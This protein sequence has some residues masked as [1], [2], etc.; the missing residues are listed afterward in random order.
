MVSRSDVVQLRALRADPRRAVLKL[1]IEDMHNAL[2]PIGTY[3]PEQEAWIEAL[4]TSQYVL[5]VKPRQLGF[6]TITLAFLFLKAL[7]SRFGRKCLSMVHEESALERLQVMTRVFHDNLPVEIQ[8]G[9][10]KNNLTVTQLAKVARDGRSIPGSMLV[11]QLA[12]GRGQ[13]RSWTYNDYHATEMSKWPSGTSAK[14]S[15]EGRSADEEAFGSAISTIHDP[16]ASVIVEST[17]DG[18]RGLFFDLYQQAVT[19][20]KWAFVF[21]K[22][23]DVARY[24]ERLT[25]PQARALEADLDS[26]ERNLV[27]KFGLTLGQIAWRRTKMK[28]LRMTGITFRREFPLTDMEPFLLDESGWFNQEALV[29]LLQHVPSLG[30]SAETLRVFLPYDPRRKYSVG[31]DTSG[32]VGRDESVI[33]VLRDDL[34]H[35][36]IWA[37]NKASPAEQ[38]HMLFRVG[39]MFGNPPSIVEANNH[40]LDVITRAQPLGVNLW[41]DEDGG[42]FWSTGSRNGNSKRMACVHMREVID[43]EWTIINDAQTIRQCQKVVE[44]Q[45]GNIEATAGHDDRFYAYALALWGTRKFWRGYEAAKLDTERDRVRR[46]RSLGTPNGR[47]GW[48]T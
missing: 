38:A 20:P 10:E 42:W 19:D 1:H 15:Q 28:T 14:R 17:G 45:N 27:R 18:P 24:S 13:A 9:Y 21:Q 43:N 8:P 33:H 30:A 25:D 12:G 29:S 11:R 5:A 34:A 3:L 41:R 7:W 16:T 26:D 31:M 39:T 37:T 4:C 32:G 46:I 48:K 47:G 6:T 35:A 44:R 40:G 36:A 23:T 22:W 2:R